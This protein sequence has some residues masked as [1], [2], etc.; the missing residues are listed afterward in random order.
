MALLPRSAPTK[1]ETEEHGEPLAVPEPSVP[2]AV[3][4]EANPVSGLQEQEPASGFQEEGAAS[5]LPSSPREGESLV[6]AEEEKTVPAPSVLGVSETP[7]NPE[8]PPLVPAPEGPA[9]RSDEAF[10]PNEA[11][12]PSETSRLREEESPVPADEGARE[13]EYEHPGEH[14]KEV[15]V[16]AHSDAVPPEPSDDGAALSVLLPQETA[17]PAAQDPDL[18]ASR[19]RDARLTERLRRVTQ[20]RREAREA[21][22]REEAPKR[23]TRLIALAATTVLL[24]GTAFALYRHIQRNSKSFI[25]QE[26][27]GLY[28][29]E[30]YDEAMASYQ[31]GFERYPDSPDFL[32][33]L[34]RSSEK[35]GQTEQSLTAWRLYL[36]QIP[37]DKA[38]NRSQALYEIGRLYALTR[39]PDKA[40]ESL[41]Q[42][43]NLDAT[44]YDTSFV[45]GRLLEE[46]NRPAE[47]LSAYRR[48]LEL[49]PSSPEAADAVKRVAGLIAP[50]PQPEADDSG[51]E[52]ARHLEVGTVALNLKRYD[53]ALSHF[54]QALSIKSDDERP[55]LGA[56]GAYQGKGQNA[57]ALKFLQD[58]Q[59]S[60]SRS[61]TLEAKIDELEQSLKKAA[62]PAPAKRRRRTTVKR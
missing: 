5:S 44:H 50:S 7:S 3:R 13:G 56:A 52:Y 33:G 31:R 59:K 2:P 23:R 10:H 29:E 45:L 38:A 8:G 49:R 48:A 28:D 18:E 53:D 62:P 20:M 4:E 40:I 12:H 26:G 43:S 6:G 37:E 22:R 47:A 34:A 32:L 21:A 9:S 27:Q 57:E 46:Q 14:P 25:A 58:A 61:V 36:N 16:H 11:F 41:I 30:R 39:M 19:D 42:A 35:A 24:L 51:R 1:T 55:W 17:A 60:V 15:G 54:N